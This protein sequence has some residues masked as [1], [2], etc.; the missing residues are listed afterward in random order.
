MS[1]YNYRAAAMFLWAATALGQFPP[2]LS[3]YE[4]LSVSRESTYFEN[5]IELEIRRLL[6]TLPYFGVFDHLEYRV[7]GSIVTLYGQVVHPDLRSDAQTLVSTIEGVGQVNNE[8][9]FLTVSPSEC[10]LRKAIFVAI[11]ANPRFRPYTLVSGGTI[12]IVVEGDR[13]TLEG[14]VSSAT[15]RLSVASVVKAVQGVSQVENHLT[16]SK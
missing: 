9:R 11:Y 3:Q 7:D 2:T 1:R 14:E 12:H 10:Q 15:D 16:V 5:R 13:V 8:I 4:P 6:R